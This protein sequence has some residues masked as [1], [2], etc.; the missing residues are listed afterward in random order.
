[1]QSRRQTASSAQRANWQR[2]KEQAEKYKGKGQPP[3]LA[4]SFKKKISKHNYKIA[5]AEVAAAKKKAKAASKPKKASTKKGEKIRYPKKIQ[6]HHPSFDF[7]LT[8]QE[9]AHRREQAPNC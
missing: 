4:G 7:N 1:M 5:A 8:V 9:M 6:V 2:I 3:Q